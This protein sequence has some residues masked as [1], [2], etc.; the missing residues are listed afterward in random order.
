M[1]EQVRVVD[2]DTPDRPSAGPPRSNWVLFALG[3][4]VGVGVA[5]VFTTPGGVTTPTATTIDPIAPPEALPDQGE[6]PTPGIG[7]VVDGFPDA[8]V[9]LVETQ[10][11]SLTHLLW[12]VGGSPIE[13]PLPSG[14]DAA[15]LDVSGRWLASTM[16][17]PDQTGNVLSVGIASSFSPLTSGVT[18][19]AWH[20]SETGDLAYTQVS[21]EEGS[22]W[23]VPP[24]RNAVLVVAGLDPRVAVSS[25]G[26]W[27]FALQ[28]PVE[29]QIV[30]Y[31][32]GGEFRSVLAGVAFGSH[33]SGWVVAA[34]GGLILLSAGGGVNRLDTD[35]EG[36]GE[37]MNAEFSPDGS[38]IAVR[39][40][41]ALLVVD[42][43]D[44]TPLLIFEGR[45]NQPDLA[46][47]SD[48]R[49]VIL[50][51]FSGRGVL[52]VDLESG[53]MAPV[54]RDRWSVGAVG[55]IPLSG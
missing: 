2:A 26:D 13:R 32:P 12:P 6:A 36:V 42:S 17:V 35:L 53:S 31:T 14:A 41:D 11:H 48:S 5:V 34:D 28:D 24:T 44:G 8:L 45:G 23:V 30:L 15:R 39:G 22:L 10:S 37:V 38:L 33:P 4:A 49:F 52:V 51:H 7:E 3:F 29:G 40:D 16:S 46:W 47:T 54:L 55:V 1:T 18:S 20:D 25:W 21:E 50:P 43:D 27:G 19:F 9:A